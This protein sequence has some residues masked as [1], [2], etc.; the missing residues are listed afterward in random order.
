MVAPWSR[1]EI[2]EAQV[3][4]ARHY[5]LTRLQEAGNLVTD[6]IRPLVVAGVSLLIG[7]CHA[8]A[9]HFGPLLLDL[10][11]ESS[12]ATPLCESLLLRAPLA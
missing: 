2:S 3:V 1:R 4:R 6:S 9:I 8:A 11:V 12:Q 10:K 5:L 7:L